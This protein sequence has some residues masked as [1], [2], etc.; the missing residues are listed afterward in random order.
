M[1]VFFVFDTLIQNRFF[2]IMRINHFRSE[3]TDVLALKQPLVLVTKPV[4]TWGSD[5]DYRCIYQETQVPVHVGFQ[6]L[7]RVMVKPRL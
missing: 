1:L 5:S 2:Q 4:K 7:S 6:E 3:L